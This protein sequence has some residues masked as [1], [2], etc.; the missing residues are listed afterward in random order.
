MSHRLGLIL[1]INH[2][3][4]LGLYMDRKLAVSNE[5]QKAFLL[6]VESFIFSCFGILTT[7]LRRVDMCLI[8]LL[9]VSH[10]GSRED[11]IKLTHE[12]SDAFVIFLEF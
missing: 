1:L 3:Q 9:Q 6:L 8:L 12:L 7:V 4:V 10:V 11:A 2:D 5:V